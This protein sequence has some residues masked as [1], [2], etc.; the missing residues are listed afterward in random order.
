MA[1]FSPLFGPTDTLRAAL[2]SSLH[3]AHRPELADIVRS[4]DLALHESGLGLQPVDGSLNPAWLEA[5]F[6]AAAVADGLPV[7]IH[8]LRGGEV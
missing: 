3:H 1:A 7:A 8:V 4:A 2:I 6:C 5:K